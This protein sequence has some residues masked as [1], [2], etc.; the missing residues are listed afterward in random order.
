MNNIATVV[1]LYTDFQKKMPTKQESTKKK[2]EEYMTLKGFS[3][4]S[5][6]TP[7]YNDDN[8][9]AHTSTGWSI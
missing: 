5:Y 9:N 1:Y 4:K 3:S 2:G 8:N 6:N 7:Y